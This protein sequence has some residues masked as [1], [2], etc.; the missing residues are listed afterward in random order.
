MPSC[1]VRIAHERG[2]AI[3]HTCAAD[4]VVGRVFEHAGFLV[5]VS[6][7]QLRGDFFSVRFDDVEDARKAND[8]FRVDSASSPI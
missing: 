8:R 1:S 2:L 3:V 7:Q 4:L 5:P 6:L